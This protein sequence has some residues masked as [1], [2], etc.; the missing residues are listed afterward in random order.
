L[1]K[2][3]EKKF[4]RWTFLKNPTISVLAF[5]NG[6]TML[7]FGQILP[8]IPILLYDQL[9]AS[10]IEIGVTISSFAITRVLSQG[11]MGSL[12]DKYGR[13]PFIVIPLFAYGLVSLFFIFAT[14]TWHIFMIRA[15]QGIFSGALWPVSDAMVM[16]I[17]DP[18]HRGKVIS[19]IQIAY[20]LGWF[21]GPFVG[22]VISNIFGM[23][24]AFGFSAGL[25]FTAFL[26]A[27]I[28]LK[29]TL[30]KKE[31][32]GGFESLYSINL[33]DHFKKSYITLK[34]FPALK[35][36]A[37]SALILQTAASLLQGYIPIFIVDALKGNEMDT[38][39][40]LGLTGVVGLILQFYAGSIGDKYGKWRV[41]R[42]GVLISVIVSPLLLLINNLSTAYI[43]IPIVL[44]ANFISMPM[45]TALVG[46][47][48]PLEERGSGYGAY[49]IVRDVSLIIGSPLGGIILETSKYF[50][51]KDLFY[52]LQ[53]L[54][55]FRFLM[56]ALTLAVIV[57]YMKSF[58]EV[59]SAIWLR[60]KVPIPE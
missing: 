23:N 31:N 24:F 56:L 8:I 55:I 2:R 37:I 58:K 40:I 30:A 27:L 47:A 46:D 22:G 49:G 48:L 35:N 52:N 17:C 29:E 33:R 28:F 19:T 41:L 53:M 39:L 34:K 20:N 57:H 4:S 13:K 32:F 15:F 14:Q 3:D 42:F 43:I 6:I 45:F 51:Q 7:G 21:A 59:D 12:S 16:D 10:E 11:P 44:G 5:S 1:S 25:S 60:S 38:G 26:V 54:F 36:L 18:K 9:H 50:S